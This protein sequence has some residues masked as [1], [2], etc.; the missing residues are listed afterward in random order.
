MKNF[1][2]SYFRPW[3]T[4]LVIGVFILMSVTGL[5]MF[6]HKS[7]GLNKLAHEWFGLLFIIGAIIHVI[8]HYASFTKYFRKPLPASLIII[9]LIFLGLS[10]LSIKMCKRFR[11]Q[12]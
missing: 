1:I 5:L 7:V 12:I 10:F 9:S 6:F 11:C 3:A 4:P 2:S 8:V